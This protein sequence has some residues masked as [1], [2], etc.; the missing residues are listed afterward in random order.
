MIKP[1][2]PSCGSPNVEQIDAD[3]Y[4]CP[5]CG[6]TFSGNITPQ[7]SSTP[8]IKVNVTNDEKTE[9]NPNNAYSIIAWIFYAIGILDF[10][11]M[12]FDY[13]FTGVYWSPIAFGVIGGIFDGLAKK[14]S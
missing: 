1:I 12:F 6:A 7:D 11:G 8:P 5:Y 13:D 2:C 10:C 4:Q 14:N 9:E 3:K